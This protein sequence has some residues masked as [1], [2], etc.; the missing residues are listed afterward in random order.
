[1]FSGQSWM[2][3]H[4]FANLRIKYQSVR[5]PELGFDAI[6]LRVVISLFILFKPKLKA[7]S[8]VSGQTQVQPVCT[9]G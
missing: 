3:A 4:N 6:P 7:N 2:D 1:M 9:V 8:R 5:H